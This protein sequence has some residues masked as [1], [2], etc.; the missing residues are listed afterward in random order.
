MIQITW[1]IQKNIKLTKSI[2][3]G[4]LYRWDGN[5]GELGHIILDNWKDFEI[6]WKEKGMQIKELFENK[7][8]IR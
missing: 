5:A 3:N 6:L 1:K 2:I 7:I 4:Y 8:K